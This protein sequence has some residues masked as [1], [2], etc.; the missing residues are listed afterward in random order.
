[1]LFQ[2]Q[3]ITIKTRAHTRTSLEHRE[4]YLDGTVATLNKCFVVFLHCLGYVLAFILYIR[5]SF[6]Y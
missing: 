3:K 4:F 5:I 2:C 1:M 6:E